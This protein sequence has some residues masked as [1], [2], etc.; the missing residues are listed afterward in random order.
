MKD[1]HKQSQGQ[2]SPVNIRLASRGGLLAGGRASL[3][4]VIAGP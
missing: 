3:Y 4:G 1:V 2:Q